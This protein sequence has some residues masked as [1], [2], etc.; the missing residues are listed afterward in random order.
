MRP[1]GGYLAD[2][3]GGVRALTILFGA[4]GL[5]FLSLSFLPGLWTAAPLI[6]FTM[7]MLGLGNGSVFQL[8][9][10]RFRK[11]IG[12]ATG[13][14]GAAGGLGGF[15]LPSMLGGFKQASGTY[16]AGFVVLGMAGILGTAL[17]ILQRREWLK[18]VTTGP[19]E[20]RETGLPVPAMDAVPE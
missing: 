19:G 9:P 5:G 20:A 1:V 7:A 18:S 11:E 4:A 2:R 15:I 16:G 8:V 13:V 17:L 12:V 6:F 14:V 3:F 10:Q